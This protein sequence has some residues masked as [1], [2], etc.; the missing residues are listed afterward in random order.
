MHPAPGDASPEPVCRLEDRPALPRRFCR[1]SLRRAVEDVGSDEIVVGY[2]H[3][4]VTPNKVGDAVFSND[5][6]G[7]VIWRRQAMDLL[8]R[9]EDAQLPFWNHF[10]N[11]DIPDEGEVLRNALVPIV[12]R[13]L[14]AHLLEAE[15]FLDGDGNRVYY[16]RR[17]RRQCRF[18]DI[19]AHKSG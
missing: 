8:L 16:R 2:H 11:L 5:D 1:Y 10:D 4:A 18:W 17:L 12:G 14:P 13:A 6:I 3:L 15:P 7:F 19:W 9:L